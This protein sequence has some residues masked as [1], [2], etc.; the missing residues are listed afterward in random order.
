VAQVFVSHRRDD[1]SEALRLAE[2]LRQAGHDVWL[3][4]WAINIGDSIVNH[5]EE[6]L[7]GSAY[8][9]LCYSDAGVMSP[10]VSREWM[11]ALYRQLEDCSVRILPVK[12]TGSIAP[13][14]LADINAADLRANWE[15][16][17]AML[18][19]SIN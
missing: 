17:L 13:A 6:G 8:L 16:G 9:I 10:W 15:K 14:I 1:A 7:G 12:L 4:E 2:D 3:D 19:R 11:S 18:L 5:I